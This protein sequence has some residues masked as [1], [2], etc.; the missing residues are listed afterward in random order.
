MQHPAQSTFTFDLCQMLLHRIRW[1][2]M[3]SILA[4]KLYVLFHVFYNTPMSHSHI[5]PFTSLDCFGFSTAPRIAIRHSGTALASGALKFSGGMS[6]EK[7]VTDALEIIRIIVQLL[8]SSSALVSLWN[9]AARSRIPK[10]CCSQARA[11]N[12]L[13]KDVW[14]Y[15]HRLG[16]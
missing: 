9:L 1:F 6:A 8:A 2:F 13:S 10:R 3:P 4:S 7:V 16:A 14:R 5:S 12:K 15:A 11:P